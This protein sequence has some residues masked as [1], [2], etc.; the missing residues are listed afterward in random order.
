M[1]EWRWL[2]SVDGWIILAGVLSSLSTALLGNFLVLRRMSL[3]GD[4]ISHAVLP[5]LAAAFLMSGSRNS[6]IMFIGAVLSGILTSWLTHW[7]GK[8][9]GIDEGASMGVVFTTLFAG[10]LILIVQAAD[11]VDLDAS[12]VF[13]G[14][15]E[16]TPFDRVKIFGT[17]IPRSIPV[18][19][20][21]FLVNVLFVASFY[22]ELKLSSFDPALATTNGFNAAFLHYCLMTLVA[23]TTV[24]C[25]E[26][27]GN[28]LVVAM[29][30]V[31]AST[32]LL[33]SDRFLFV[34]VLSLI[35][36]S[37]SA[38]TGHIAA[39]SLP[40]AFGMKSTG[41]AGM[42]AVSAGLLFFL[43]SLFAPQK[44][45]LIQWLRRQRLSLRILSEDVIAAAYRFEE[46]GLPSVSTVEL[47]KL[48]VASPIL[49]G[50][51][52]MRHRLRGWF[53]SQGPDVR[54]TELG[55]NAAKNL[56]KTHRLWEN[57]LIDSGASLPN[58]IH[59]QAEQLEH[60]TNDEL[61]RQLE[62]AGGDRK[63]D[64]HGREIPD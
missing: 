63:T 20:I 24:A 21:V 30:I 43:V 23:V 37:I 64:P 61:R 7:L 51:I 54:L 12:C 62:V 48:L 2:W 55:R 47:S 17:E 44:G 1:M 14:S 45:V 5:G 57:Y 31:P 60:F 33:L 36:A 6:S 42:M 3:L 26:S 22:K 41:T 16:M 27:V 32:A 40:A 53:E 19:T 28:I 34:L 8:H 35:I 38:V 11:S 49:I 46:K 13:Y 59:P 56:V 15:I 29:L 39:V 50:L 9:G 4:A 58:R 18:L 10:G 25:F 52:R